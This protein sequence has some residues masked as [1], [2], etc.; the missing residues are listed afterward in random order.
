MLGNGIRKDGSRGRG[1]GG[2]GFTT[3]TAVLVALLRMLYV[4]VRAPGA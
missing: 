2:T 4:I 1:G 3:T